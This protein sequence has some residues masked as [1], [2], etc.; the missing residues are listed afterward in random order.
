MTE[1]LSVLKY[2]KNLLL[3]IFCNSDLKQIKLTFSL[4]CNE[5]TR[6]YWI[7]HH[8]DNFYKIGF[9]TTSSKFNQ[10]LSLIAF[11]TF[12]I[13]YRFFFN[14]IFP[15]NFHYLNTNTNVSSVLTYR[16][17]LLPKYL[18]HWLQSY[19]YDQKLF[20]QIASI[21]YHYL[22]NKIQTPFTIQ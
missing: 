19:N 15:S 9:R 2:I 12:L 10:F 21:V 1:K 17:S 20:M 11:A 8:W 22:Q 3:Q 14:L 6:S 16:L 5:L 4:S 13:K 18:L 7:I